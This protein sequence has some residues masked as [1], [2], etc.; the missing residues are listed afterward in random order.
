MLWLVLVLASQ[1]VGG[2]GSCGLALN[3]VLL[4]GCCRESRLQKFRIK[5]AWVYGI[6]KLE[7]V[8]I[9]CCFF[10][11]RIW[12]HWYPSCSSASWIVLESEGPLM[13]IA[14][15]PHMAWCRHAA[16]GSKVKPK[17]IVQCRRIPLMPLDSCREFREFRLLPCTC[18]IWLQCAYKMMYC[19]Q[20]QLD[21][22]HI[23]IQR[24]FWYFRGLFCAMF[25][26]KIMAEE[27]SK[28]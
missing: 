28:C 11:T 5:N 21:H 27:K 2:N 9:I 22:A 16:L 13:K 10:P 26:V 20:I 18:T 19:L 15:V 14:N 25:F 7:I 17:L 12:L 4:Y 8:L 1:R 23:D 6:L 24:C 3:S